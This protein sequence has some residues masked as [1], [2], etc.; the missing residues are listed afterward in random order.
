MKRWTFKPGLFSGMLLW[1]V[2]VLVLLA[3][4]GQPALAQDSTGGPD[5]SP[6]TIHVVQQDET[7]PD[8]A[9]L[10]AITVDEI[11]QA[12]GLGEGDDLFVGQR[13][14]IPRSG[15][16]AAGMSGQQVVVGFDDNLYTLAGRYGVSVESLGALI[17]AVN[18]LGLYVGQRVS[19]PPVE[20]P[21]WYGEGSLARLGEGEALWHVALRS[22][23]NLFE[24][25]LRNGI[26]DPVVVSPGRMLVVP[27]EAAP[28]TL[29]PDPWESVE[30]HP[31][32]LEQG[33]SGGLRVTTSV[34]GT[35]RGSFLS[36]ELN[37][38]SEGVLHQAVFGVHRWTEPG[39][40]PLTL[41][42]EDENGRVWS[43][44]K[45]I[46]VIDGRYDRE[47]VRLPPAVAAILDDAQAVQDEFRYIAQ[48][49]SG[50][51]PQRRWDGLLLLPAPGVMT[52]AF[53]T[54]RS[55]NDGGFNSFHAG[56]DLAASTGTPVYAPA[57]G[58]VVDT[59]LLDVRG[60]ATIVD[61]G[62]GVYTGY[63]HQSSILVNPGDVVTTGQQIGTVGNTGL[64]TASHLHWE[65]WVGGIQV[66]P[67]QWVR[68][69]FP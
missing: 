56:A 14:L 22:N 21:A 37:V 41:S 33:R 66:D 25:A 32:P 35:L 30:F 7:L 68:E 67:L 48:T 39:L 40:Y 16:A 55:Y 49:M 42:F 47:V 53:G 64:S 10:Y 15:S 61:H 23:S 20:Q 46:L 34:P 43:L 11:R 29:L 31:V 18:P 65:M 62:W 17:K 44:S 1:P 6:I 50:F 4:A 58:V 45:S 12:N 36:A 63:W 38:V 8:I 3:F 69:E 28:T 54:V 26:A 9:A 13:L 60:L 24:L 5:T 57:D 52:S 19:I 51:T 2:V 27:S 59:G